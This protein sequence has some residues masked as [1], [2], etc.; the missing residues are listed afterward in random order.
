MSLGIA[1]WN[2]SVRTESLCDGNFTKASSYHARV[3][4]NASSAVVGR[5][6]RVCLALLM[7][8]LPENTV[9]YR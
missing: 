2:S 3:S 1:V 6:W 7:S 5:N 9:G 4:L 8:M